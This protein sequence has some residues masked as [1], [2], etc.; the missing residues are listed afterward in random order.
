[1][2][3][4][5]TQRQQRSCPEVVRVRI[6]EL[7]RRGNEYDLYMT[8]RCSTGVP[9]I[10]L[11]KK[12]GEKKQIGY[13]QHWSQDADDHPARDGTREVTLGFPT[14]LINGDLYRTTLPVNTD[15]QEHLQKIAQVVVRSR[16][17]KY[18]YESEESKADPILRVTYV[19]ES[20]RRQVA[21]V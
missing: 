9:A 20:L 1:M 18:I 15:V 5:K 4:E 17:R 2:T 21:R 11:E 13:Q 8:V 19:S 14:F 6:S 7:E 16:G 12:P 10:R 3:K